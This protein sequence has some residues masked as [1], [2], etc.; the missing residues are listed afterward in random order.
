MINN[1]YH[2]YALAKANG[3][4]ELST[5]LEQH[6]M[7]IDE[8]ENHT[9]YTSAG[10][11][12]AEE[13]NLEGVKLLLSLGAN[14]NFIAY[15][16]AKGDKTDLLHYLESEHEPDAN[17][18][19]FGAGQGKHLELAKKYID[20]KNANV[21]WYA[22]GLASGKGLGEAL[23]LH[24][25]YA[26]GEWSLKGLFIG[27]GYSVTQ[28]SLKALEVSPELIEKMRA[29]TNGLHAQENFTPPK[30]QNEKFYSALGIFSGRSNSINQD[31]IMKDRLPATALASRAAFCGR[32]SNAEY[33][34]VN[35]AA[36]P[37]LIAAGAA[38]G[39]NVDYV[40]WL[41]L[42][43]NIDIHLIAFAAAL[44]GHSKYA[45]FLRT[46]C[47]ANFIAILQGTVFSGDINYCEYLQKIESENFPDQKKLIFLGSVLAGHYSYA[48]RV[49]LF[50][51]K[52][53][54]NNRIMSHLKSLG[55]TNLPLLE[56]IETQ[57]HNEMPSYK[58]KIQSDPEQH[59]ATSRDLSFESLEKI[60]SIGK[61]MPEY[62]TQAFE[63]SSILNQ[64]KFTH[65]VDLSTSSD[66]NASKKICIRRITSNSPILFPSALEKADGTDK[67]LNFT[68]ANNYSSIYT[69]AK[70][71]DEASLN[72][73]L[74][75]QVCLDEREIGTL[76]TSAGAK[77]AEEG[78]FDAVLILLKL[79]ANINFIAY[80]AAKGA[81]IKLLSSLR[82]LHYYPDYNW[83][84]MGA[85]EGN[86]LHSFNDLLN[87]SNTNINWIAKGIA[88]GRRINYALFL[89]K[90]N[91]CLGWVVGGLL[92][93]FDYDFIQITLRSLKLEP[94]KLKKAIAFYI[95]FKNKTF[96]SEF[97]KFKDAIA[98][99][100]AAGGHF[101]AA[102]HF[103][104]T[105]GINVN[106][107]AAGAALYGHLQYSEYLRTQYSADIN[108]IAAYAAE[109]GNLTYVEFLITK[110]ADKHVAASKAAEGGHANFAEHLRRLHKVDPIKISKGAALSGDISYCEYLMHNLNI[111]VKL[112]STWSLEGGHSFFSRYLQ[113]D[114]SITA[115][116]HPSDKDQEYVLE[117]PSASNIYFVGI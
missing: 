68:V 81:Q 76:Y 72:K 10:A 100:Y 113:K 55:F 99:G 111:D 102:E 109:G 115:E 38:A 91:A 45:E 35:Y 49:Q 3:R 112:M 34:R 105:E 54:L 9:L 86:C 71:K 27:R 11:K 83:I 94:E 96:S 50:F 25:K 85:A 110:D 78:N 36:D 33:L 53:V 13:G 23:E 41:R 4:D 37:H 69:F 46:R 18:I 107:L 15:G 75:N 114:R 106:L 44:G 70:N 67:N 77:L 30:S 88:L 39:G 80:G 48:K 57:R 79:G 40:E 103:R 56:E 82:E 87:N 26:T 7:C 73:L 108:T 62:N 16:A 59:I 28:D 60:S 29:F 97:E 92:M 51:M 20:T 63:I 32:R 52:A 65:E 1:F 8:R 12:L 117:A 84:A 101:G 6:S 116:D 43:C 2:I 90:K 21:S 19:V 89:A 31:W 98:F 95:G 22:M 5:A 58:K 93:A 66:L 17:W 47:A 74:V 24:Q 42:N 14:V 64:P 61:F 104:V